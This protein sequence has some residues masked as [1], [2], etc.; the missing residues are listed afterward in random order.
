MRLC[1]TVTCEQSRV[2]TR[3]LRAGLIIAGLTSGEVVLAAFSTGRA[4]GLTRQ[5][6]V[7]MVLVG[8]ITIL[9]GLEAEGPLWVDVSEIAVRAF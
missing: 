8:N 9:A 6:F 7:S 3:G 1:V 5:A 2:H 4:I